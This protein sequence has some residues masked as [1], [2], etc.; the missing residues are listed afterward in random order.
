MKVSLICFALLLAVACQ[1]AG[2]HNSGGSE[3]SIQTIEATSPIPGVAVI[4]PTPEIEV[5]NRDSNEIIAGKGGAKIRIGDTRS[6]ILEILGD[7]SEEY[8][9]AGRQCDYVEMHWIDIKYG[10][11]GIYAFLK[12][13][14]VSQLKFSSSLYETSDGLGFESTPADVRKAY[15][16]NKRLHELEEYILENS[17]QE[18]NG[19]EDLIFWVDQGQGIAFQFN[20]YRKQKKRRSWSIEV[21]EP[22]IPFLPETCVLQPQRFTKIGDLSLK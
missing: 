1:T 22:D 21:F 17:G 3:I 12:D 13:G 18:H 19:G 10:G 4:S 14:K 20:F 6:Q 15:K 16:K 2:D 7:P 11:D 8:D 9:L 5:Q